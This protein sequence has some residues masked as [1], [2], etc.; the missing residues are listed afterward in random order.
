[1][2][3]SW[4][5][6]PAAFYGA[7]DFCKTIDFGG[8]K[9][10]TAY[11]TAV[12]AYNLYVDGKK[13]GDAVLAP[14]WTS[15][16]KM[17]QYQEYD[18]TSL[19]GGK[20]EVTVRLA[21]GW[22][23]S[24]TMGYKHDNDIYHA[25]PAV[26]INIEL[27]Y[28]DGKK[29]VVC[30]D[31]DWKTYTTPI[32]FSDIYDGE[33]VD[34]TAER[35]FLGKARVDS[36]EAT[37][38]PQIGE[39]VREKER[40][41]A[42]ELIITP[43][44]EKVID[45][46]QNLAGYVEIKIKGNRGDKISISHAEVLDKYGNFYTD[47][48]RTAQNICTYTL[49]GEEDVLKPSFSFQ[50]YRYIRLDEWPFDDVDTSCFT[51]V[52]VYSDM[53]RTGYFECGNDKVNKLY[54]NIIWGQRSNFVDVPTDCPQRDERL[55]WTGDAQVFCR[56]ACINYDAERFFD[57]WLY[58][59]AVDQFDDG[60][61]FPVI[62][63]VKGCS[64]RKSAAWA[65]ASVIVPMEVYAAYGNKALLER[66]FPMM[67][68]WVN[69]IHSFGNEEY[70][71]VGGYHYGDWLAM[72]AGEGEYRGATQTDLIASAYFA[73]STSLLI[74]AGKILG[75]D[76]TEYEELLKNIKA[77]FREAFMSDGMPIIYP[78]ADAFD[79][80]RKVNNMTQTAIV[81]ILK[82]GLYEGE[83]ERMAL[84][85]KLVEL[86]RLNDNRMTT[87]FVGTPYI[88]HA[89]SENGYSSVAYDL[90]LQEKNPSWLFSVNHGATTMWEHW[91]SVNDEGD[92]WSTD[93]N[94]F[95][96]YAYGSV[97]DWIFGVSAG[98]KTADDGAGYTHVTV[99]PH[100]D[101]RLGHVKCSIETHSGLLSS[102]WNYKADGSV[103][104][105]I[106][107]PNGCRAEIL[108]PGGKSATVGEGKYVF[109]EKE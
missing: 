37:L 34:L 59:M 3:E 29:E 51:S 57:K 33:T 94:S 81:L 36:V 90:L 73:Y 38:L 85:E 105:E 10:A 39:F 63:Y 91:D 43:K 88:L 77:S 76:M 49:S 22:T 26:L 64:E 23:G 30:G 44:G 12:G 48:Y 55:G 89:L 99:Q 95:N 84:A 67:E 31:S 62:P 102:K 82:F 83:A 56:T 106:V 61:I 5:K 70:L 11:V 71:W 25:N 21:R 15:V 45:F 107:I 19:V 47:N 4:I 14:G 75:K 17:L 40:V 41:A 86:I 92:F 72:D 27:E 7:V 53:K 20:S 18:I 35:R 101:R 65:D 32:L 74:K 80:K 46:G 24:A 79:T 8:V 69:Y 66:C 100:P 60:A 9:R 13:V 28:N 109:T 97:Y 104:Y 78:K 6:S 98:I 96:H 16:Q 50:G 2:Q 108:L 58:N 103:E 1:M 52:A 54:S 42:V 93:M 87:G 68:K